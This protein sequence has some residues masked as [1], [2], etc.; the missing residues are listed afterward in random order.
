MGPAGRGPAGCA[1]LAHELHDDVEAVVQDHAEQTHQVFVPDLP[2]MVGVR[3]R[4]CLL[5]PGSRGKAGPCP[6]MRH[7]RHG[8]RFAEE[9]LGSHVTLDVLHGHLLP[10]ILALQDVWEGMRGVRFSP[11]PDPSQAE[12][13]NAMGWDITGCPLGKPVAG[14]P[15]S[16]LLAYLQTR[17]ARCGPPGRGAAGS[18]ASRL[19]TG[20][21]AG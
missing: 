21:S 12:L 8:S 15:P 14:E 5:V 11:A 18:A 2:E 16:H 6:P 19:G 10:H 9:G 1:H 20:T 17:L 3:L 13:P 7:S 4:G